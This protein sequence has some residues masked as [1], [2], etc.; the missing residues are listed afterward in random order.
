MRE[1]RRG[2]K[3]RML[4]DKSSTNP[5]GPKPFLGLG[6]IICFSSW[7][8]KYKHRPVLTGRSSAKEW[9]DLYT[10]IAETLK[11]CSHVVNW[12]FFDYPGQYSDLYC[13]DLEPLSPEPALTCE[14]SSNNNQQDRTLENLLTETLTGM[15]PFSMPPPPLNNPVPETSS[16]ENEGP[17]AKRPRMFGIITPNH[18]SVPLNSIPSNQHQVYPSTSAAALQHQQYFQT[19]CPPNTNTR[20]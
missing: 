18:Q 16:D 10:G 8:E 5:T 4:P 13:R 12:P 14:P 7:Y 3:P 15:H 17:A 2:G 20:N 9:A 1:E 19:G 11:T 6:C